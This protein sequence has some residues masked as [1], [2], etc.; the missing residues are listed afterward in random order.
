VKA[1]WWDVK[2]VKKRLKKGGIVPREAVR[3]ANPIVPQPIVHA[4][5]TLLK[6][7]RASDIRPTAL[8]R[9]AP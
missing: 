4:V 8:A 7:L 1:V 3:K 6:R 2:K 9:A 5:W